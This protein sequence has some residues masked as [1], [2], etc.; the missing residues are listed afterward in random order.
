MRVIGPEQRKALLPAESIASA[1]PIPT[2]I[3]SS[4]EYLPAPQTEKQREVETRLME[5]AA[6][7]AK[8]HGT[9]RRRFFQTAAGMAA[10]YLAM[11]QVYGPLF[12]ASPAEAAT[13]ELADER[14]AALKSQ[15][16][17]DAHTHF[18]RDDPSPTIAD[19]NRPGGLVW[20]RVQAGRFRLNQDLVGKPQ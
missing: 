10:S 5:M 11:N 20:Q 16:I 17:F 19:G 12:D 1:A 8:K 18:V 9:S 3:I 2:Q 14:A 7:L 13:P 4:D 15:L 6:R